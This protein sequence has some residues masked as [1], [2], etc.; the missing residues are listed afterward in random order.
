MRE[1]LPAFSPPVPFLP[2]FTS[3]AVARLQ[4]PKPGWDRATRSLQTIS[5][6]PVAR[7]NDQLLR[8]NKRFRNVRLGGRSPGRSLY[9]PPSANP[10]TP[11]TADRFCHFP[12]R[13]FAVFPPAESVVSLRVSDLGILTSSPPCSLTRSLTRPR[14]ALVVPATKVAL[15]PT[16]RFSLDCVPQAPVFGPQLGTKVTPRSSLPNAILLL[17]VF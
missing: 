3:S 4:A 10:A 13:V 14:R 12:L 8:Q 9:Q 5:W 2:P 1:P 16:A 6:F 17:S 7:T 11:S 15:I